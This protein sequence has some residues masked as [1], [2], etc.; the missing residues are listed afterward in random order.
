MV[1]TSYGIHNTIS[2]FLSLFHLNCVF[3]FLILYFFL[4]IFRS[5]SQTQMQIWVSIHITGSKLFSNNPL[6]LFFFEKPWNSLRHPAA[7]L[8]FFIFFL[9]G[10]LVHWESVWWWGG[11]RSLYISGSKGAGRQRGS[12][13]EA[14]GRGEDGHPSPLFSTTH[15]DI[16]TQLHI[17]PSPSFCQQSKVL[18]RLR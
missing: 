4:F 3:H 9:S 15:T 8:F 16:H 13:S 6:L 1:C 5:F 12:Q 14:R 7:T 17:P 2:C 18:V 10:L 11:G